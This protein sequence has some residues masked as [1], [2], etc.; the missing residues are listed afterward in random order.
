MTTAKIDLHDKHNDIN[1]NIVYG[2]AVAQERVLQGAVSVIRTTAKY[3]GPSG[4]GS[5]TKL[6]NEREILQALIK[7][8]WLPP[9]AYDIPTPT[10]GNFEEGPSFP[11]GYTMPNAD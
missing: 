1:G 4:T 8:G 9:S 7:A 5:T 6:A 2:N 10:T 11:E 3:R